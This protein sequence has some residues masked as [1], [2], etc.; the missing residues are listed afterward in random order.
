M[1]GPSTSNPTS[2][3]T[4]PESTAS[5]PSSTS[6]TVASPSTTSSSATGQSQSSGGGGAVTSVGSSSSSAASSSTS[7]GEAGRMNN[8]AGDGSL[9][10][11]THAEAPVLVKLTQFSPLV[12]SWFCICCCLHILKK[13]MVDKSTHFHLKTGRART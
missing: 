11:R 5:S 12:D 9:L 8:V 10:V 7:K 13:Q 6:V 1:Q 4:G 3:P 2:N